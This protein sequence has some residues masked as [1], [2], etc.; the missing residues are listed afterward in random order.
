VWKTLPNSRKLNIFN[1]FFWNFHELQSYVDLQTDSNLLH[2][3]STPTPNS[4]FQKI[5]EKANNEILVL[6]ST[7]TNK[8]KSPSTKMKPP[9]PIG[10]MLKATPILIAPCLFFFHPNKI[11][12]SVTCFVYF[13][14]MSKV[15]YLKMWLN[16][17]MEDFNSLAI[18]LGRLSSAIWQTIWVGVAGVGVVEKT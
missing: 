4:I 14:S 12:D 18:R 6:K 13:S 8:S 17:H 11:S 3:K 1:G 5:F 10:L 16:L 9:A 2:S 7:T 15:I